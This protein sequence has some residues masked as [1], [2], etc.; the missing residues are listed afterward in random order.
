MT[1]AHMHNKAGEMWPTHK[2]VMLQN[3]ADYCQIKARLHSTRTLCIAT[4]W[5]GGG[6][7]VGRSLGHV[8]EVWGGGDLLQQLPQ[9]EGDGF[10]SLLALDQHA[11]HRVAGP[12]PAPPVF[13]CCFPNRNFTRTRWI[14]FLELPN[15]SPQTATNRFLIRFQISAFTSPP[16]PGGHFC[17]GSLECFFRCSNPPPE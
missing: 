13:P 5:G 15:C 2:P 4:T 16:V 11:S 17:V 3:N 10:T 6:A 12:P 9:P 7:A 1:R 8:H 14:H